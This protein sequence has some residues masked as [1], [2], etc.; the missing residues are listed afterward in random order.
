MHEY[1]MMVERLT[2]VASMWQK[3]NFVVL[4]AKNTFAQQ[5][6]IC[7]NK[8]SKIIDKCQKA[9][10]NRI[11]PHRFCDYLIRYSFFTILYVIS[12]KI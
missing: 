7:F 9:C 8:Y 6:I 12:P 2:H 1:R 3:T 11:F 10:N 5:L 4:N